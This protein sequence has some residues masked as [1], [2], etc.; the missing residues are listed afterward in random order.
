VRL[1]NVL[2]LAGGYAFRRL[3]WICAAAVLCARPVVGQPETRAVRID[4]PPKIDGSLDDPCWKTPPTADS[5]SRYTTG[6]PAKEPTRAWICC[7][8]ERIYVAF[9]CKDSRPDSVKAQQRKRRGSLGT[10]DHVG[11]DIDASLSGRDNA[12]FDVNARGTRDEYVPGSS[13]SKTEWTGDWDAAARIGPDGWTAE[14]AIPFRM[15]DYPKG[16][17]GMGILFRRRHARS[18]EL[19]TSPNPGPTYDIKAFLRWTGLRLPSPVTRPVFMTYAS[20]AAGGGAEETFQAGLDYKQ[21]I[22]YG[23][24]ALLTVKPDFRSVEQDIETIDFSYVPRILPDRRPFFQEGLGLTP[25]EEWVFYSRRIEKVDYGAKLASQAGR[26]AYSLLGTADGGEKHLYGKYRWAFGQES[27]VGAALSSATFPADSGDVAGLWTRISNIN[28]V[29]D[30]HGRIQVYRSEHMGKVGYAKLISFHRDATAG[31]VSVLA[32]WRDIE[33]TY[34]PVDGEVQ[35][36][37]VRGGSL[38]ISYYKLRNTGYWRGWRATLSGGLADRHVWS[39][40]GPPKLLDDHWQAAYEFWGIGKYVSLGYL[41]RRR[42][43]D[44]L[45][46]VYHDRLLTGS[47]SWNTNDL[48]AGKGVSAKIGRQY[49]GPYLFWSVWKGKQ[50]N[51][52]FSASVSLEREKLSGPNSQSQRQAVLSANY[53]L[54]DEKSVSCRLVSGSRGT[55]FSAGY[56]QQ[57]RRGMDAFLLFG[58]PNT[59]TTSSRVILKVIVPYSP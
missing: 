33:P 9:E 48:Y 58:D 54:T 14:L 2:R 12:W 10:D 49:G 56:R 18:D 17:Q 51:D 22:G 21:R 4:T 32:S 57:V 45:P 30:D 47:V 19:W 11:I 27:Y 31:R 40:T 50:I 28:S 41:D 39:P 20:V 1:S 15:L 37:D 24:N 42:G 44:E 5:F 7:D 13:G 29:R 3:A 46:V 23:T 16:Q 36:P 25:N 26:H 55:N 8:A 52:S 43:D 53:D 35:E 34:D 59:E 6:A 38:D